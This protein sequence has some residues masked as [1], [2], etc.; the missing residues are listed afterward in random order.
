MCDVV[1]RQLDTKAACVG[2]KEQPDARVPS[3]FDKTA[4]ILLFLREF[5]SSAQI[6]EI[7][8]RG[9]LREEEVSDSHACTNQARQ[10]HGCSPGAGMT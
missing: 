10:E 5:A 7:A 6:F 9:I 2:D 3:C 1:D 4:E 8:R